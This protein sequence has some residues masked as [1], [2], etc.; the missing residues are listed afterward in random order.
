MRTIHTH[1]KIII[2]SIL[3]LGLAFSIASCSKQKTETTTEPETAEI[4]P[5][6]T[7]ED[8][9]QSKH[10]TVSLDTPL[11]FNE[12]IQPI[13]SVNCYHCHG[14]DSGTR[15]PED[16]P[17]RLDSAEGVFA[18]RDS[19]KPVI[20]KGDPDNSYLMELMARSGH[21]SASH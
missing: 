13:L 3:I 2:S 1:F 16:E 14:P 11:S 19:G 4:T 10:E 21:A 6:T 8:A 9:Y 12:H 15:L 18:L 5:E 7:K 20:I 17:L